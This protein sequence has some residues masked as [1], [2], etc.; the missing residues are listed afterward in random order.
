MMKSVRTIVLSA[1]V[2]FASYGSILASTTGSDPRP[3]TTT[4]STSTAI[5]VSTVLSTLGL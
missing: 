5:V 2:L 1:A 3:T 4:S